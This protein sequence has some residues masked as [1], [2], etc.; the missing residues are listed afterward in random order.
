MGVG[1][2]TWALSSFRFNG[3]ATTRHRWSCW[4]GGCCQEL[5]APKN[6]NQG[7]SRFALA[8]CKSSRVAIE[9]MFGERLWARR[10]IDGSSRCRA[11]AR[12]GGSYFCIKVLQVALTKFLMKATKNQ[13]IWNWKGI[14]FR[15]AT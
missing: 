6:K 5:E 14:E 1:D 2:R 10:R 3:L 7:K 12:I 8:T 9:L 4:K 15:V 11:V 13:S